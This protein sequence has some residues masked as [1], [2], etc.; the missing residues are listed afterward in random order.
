MRRVRLDVP[1]GRGFETPIT[2]PRP[3]SLESIAQAVNE[4]RAVGMVIHGEPW[5][6]I[7]VD[8]RPDLLSA[9]NEI[10]AHATLKGEQGHAA[11]CHAAASARARSS[12][13]RRSLNGGISSSRSIMV[14][15][16]L[17]RAHAAL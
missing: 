7:T 16:P 4:L 15:T 3:D 9:A 13:V 2:E 17:K 8:L 6:R 11:R 5:R 10:F 14:A 1:A 12:S